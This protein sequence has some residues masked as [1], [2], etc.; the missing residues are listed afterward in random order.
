MTDEIYRS[1]FRL[2]Y[3]LYEQLKEAADENHRSVNAELVACLQST[4]LKQRLS[5]DLIP[6]AK[7]REMSAA[8]RKNIPAEIKSRV[9]ESINHSILH[10]LTTAHVD[11]QDMGLESLPDDVAESLTDSVNKT[12]SGVGYEVEWDGFISLWVNFQ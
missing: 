7:A 4:I 6:A 12:L 2:P 8:F 10:G 3:P 11:L 9:V 5:A 1:Q